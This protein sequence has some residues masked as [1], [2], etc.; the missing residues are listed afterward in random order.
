[1]IK[2]TDCRPDTAS[3]YSSTF[4]I[5]ATDLLC[6]NLVTVPRLRRSW[7][8]IEESRKPETMT[9]EV[10]HSTDITLACEC[11]GLGGIASRGVFSGCGNGLGDKDQPYPMPSRVCRPSEVPTAKSGISPVGHGE[12]HQRDED[13]GMRVGWVTGELLA[14]EL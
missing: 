7:K 10:S 13:P 12:E 8:K 3:L 5:L 9:S 6:C 11:F 1:M 4:R 2:H 14:L